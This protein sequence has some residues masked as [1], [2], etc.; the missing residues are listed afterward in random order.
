MENI[1]KGYVT[2]M[3]NKIFEEAYYNN[4]DYFYQCGDD[5]S[6]KTKIL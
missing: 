5:I 6:F 2:L 3:W 4:C 1:E